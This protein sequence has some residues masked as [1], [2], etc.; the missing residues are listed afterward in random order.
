MP[1]VR[2]NEKGEKIPDD[3]A[4]FVK[5][6][7]KKSEEREALRD[8][9]KKE[10]VKNASMFVLAAAA[11]SVGLFYFVSADLGILTAVLASSSASILNLWSD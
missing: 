3:I 9:R 2:M 7:I 6:S 1:I 11:A 10:S 4:I 8:I 5:E